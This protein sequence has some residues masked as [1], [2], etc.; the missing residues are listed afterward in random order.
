MKLR[1]LLLSLAVLV[2]VCGVVW[3]VQRPAPVAATR[4]SRIG[5]RVA[6]PATIADAARVRIHSADKSIE[7]ARGENGAWSLVGEPSLPADV[8]RLTRLTGDLIEPKIE[9]LVS[10]KAE[11]L[12]TFDLDSAGV[13]FLD[14]A[15]KTLLD[16]DLGKTPDGGGRILRY[17]DETKAY[18]ARLNVYLDV[19]PASWR[20]TALVR[21]LQPEDVASVA[22]GFP[23]TGAPVVVSRTAKDAPWT[24]PSTPA[25]QQVKS[26]LITTQLGNLTGLRYTDLAP[27]LDPDVVAAR[28]LPR[29]LTL[30]TFDG[31][32]VTVSIGRAPELPT[33]PA[34]ELK[35]GETAPPTPPAPP[36]PVYVEVTDSKAAPALAEAAK[37][38]AFEI[39]E[40]IHSSLPADSAALFE[41]VPA[42][43]AAAVP[44]APA[45]TGDATSSSASPAGTAPAA[46]RESI[47]VVTEP[48]GIDGSV[49]GETAAP[50]A[51]PSAGEN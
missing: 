9:R 7:L 42:P 39:G 41:P 49:G 12:A 38:H 44:P 4:D 27:K 3:W 40:W 34:P 22:I 33:P 32:S 15:G 14:A 8:S 28:I 48:V 47:S 25:G 26:S 5:Q 6:D 31:R 18:F 13:T 17:G 19:E 21:E 1:P 37:T 36:R 30:T 45:T 2:P 10:E 29:E 24:S 16:I 23:D 20:D 50:A 35:D 51:S 43:P 46:K 11:K